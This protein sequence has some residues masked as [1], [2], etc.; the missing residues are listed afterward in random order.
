MEGRDALSIAREQVRQGRTA[1]AEETC[2]RI[3]EMHPN[4]ADAYQLLALLA[5]RR[6]DSEAALK[7]V[8]QAI[9]IEPGHIAYVRS[10]IELLRALK[11]TK[12]IIDLCQEILRERSELA[13]IH[14]DLGIA[15]AS[16]GKKVEAFSAFSEALRIK[17]ELVS[18]RS[19]LGIVCYE[20]GQF[21]EAASHFRQAL[22]RD[23]GSLS[24]HFNLGR[25]LMAMGEFS[26]AERSFESALKVAPKHSSALNEL[27][28]LL[29]K[30]GRPRDARICFLR[31]TRS[32]PASAIS[33]SNLGTSCFESGEIENAVASYRRALE[34]DPGYANAHYN[35]GVTLKSAGQL[36]E[37][38]N[39]LDSA[40]SI[41]PD[42]EEAQSF[43]L[44][45]LAHCCEWDRVP[46]LTSRVYQATRQSLKEGRRPAETPFLNI[47]RYSDPGY[48]FR[49]ASAW[50]KE[51]SQFSGRKSK[52]PSRPKGGGKRRRIRIGYASADFRNHP[53]GHFT[54]SLLE[55]HDRSQFE[56]RLYSYGVDDGSVYRSSAEECSDS[57]T[58]ISGVPDSEAAQLIRADRVDVLIDLTG[59]TTGG[60]NGDLCFASG[61][62]P[63]GVS[64]FLSLVRR[65]FHGLPY[66]RSGC[67]A[68]E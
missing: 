24:A 58:E 41:N 31:A 64:W 28:R 49:V 42:H 46:D 55:G 8:E 4:H 52:S 23:I 29:L 43:L 17:P 19:N 30:M 9:A 45:T 35:L 15:W 65:R 32:N 62:N 13:E 21:P 40:L 67:H 38:K 61:S 16:E 48:N 44:E 14:L 51:V 18:A 66:R 63:G 3:L 57:F 11:R 54:R 68:D 2:R 7:L 39:S 53:V 22:K 34:I 37:A 5:F 33:F 25:T 27:G 10:K 56:V 6:G 59:H 50:A 1:M 26:E 60:E 36:E 12:E 20:S 47:G